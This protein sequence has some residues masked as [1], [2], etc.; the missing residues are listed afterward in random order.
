MNMDPAASTPD[1]PRFPIRLFRHLRFRHGLFCPRCGHT[2]IHRWG[3]YGC[4]RRYRCLGCR[5]TF[6][7][8]TGT[9]L[10]YL[11][12]VE[13][14][15]R[16][17]SLALH[18]PTVRAAAHRLGIDPSTSF[19]WRHRLL[20]SLC[21]TEAVEL[22]PQISVHIDWFARSE[23]GSRA[24]NR[25][26]RRVAFFGLSFQTDPVWAVFGCDGEGRSLG[27]LLDAPRPSPPSV[28]AVLE[29]RI[30]PGSTLL[31]RQGW[32][33]VIARTADQLDLRYDKE[34]A[35]PAHL[36]PGRL[37]VVRLRTWLVRFH[38]VATRYLDNYLVWFRLIDYGATR[39]QAPP[40]ASS[41][42]AGEFP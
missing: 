21:R 14:W 12:R 1:T 30:R 3:R 26:A 5:R 23:K 16:F 17:C 39:L 6:S 4:R 37:Y 36:E 40:A 41:L 25:P 8:F 31:S 11:K 24:L 38:G 35:S 18:A 28:R 34:P 29:K 7:D 27:A 20:A 33:S 19:R 22:E 13:L 42:L 10:A 32:G 9:P 2:R 15:P